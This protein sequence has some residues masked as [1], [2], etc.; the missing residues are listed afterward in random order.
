MSAQVPP[1]PG[2][3]WPPQESGSSPPPWPAPWQHQGWPGQAPRTN[4]LAIA[5]LVLGIVG[6]LFFVFI[7]PPVLALIFGLVSHGQIRRSGG[8]QAGSGMA[9]AG[10]VLGIVGALLFVLLV[11][12]GGNVHFYVR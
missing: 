12:T 1:P 3:P 11:A 8:A 6:L 4:G 10:I 5:S 2:Q 7:V 9:I